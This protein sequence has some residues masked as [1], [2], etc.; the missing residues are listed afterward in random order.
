MGAPFAYLSKE[1]YRMNEN[2]T[3]LRRAAGEAV[4]EGVCMLAFAGSG[5]VGAWLVHRIVPTTWSATAVILLSGVGAILLGAPVYGSVDRAIQP[6]R[7][8]LR[9]PA[10]ALARQASSSTSGTIESALA[11]VTAA[12]E[13]DAA[14]QAARDTCLFAVGTD[15]F[16]RDATHWCGYENGEAT[17]HLTDDLVIHYRSNQT[18]Y[19]RKEEYTLLSSNPDDDPVRITSL[20]QIRHHLAAR[21]AGLPVSQPTDEQALTVA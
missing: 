8:I 21:A 9:R 3:T 16:L 20:A 17:F 4:T 18:R 6:L 13:T 5:A 19:G 2:T 12:T 10:N 11:E 7:R 15:H 1:S 14:R